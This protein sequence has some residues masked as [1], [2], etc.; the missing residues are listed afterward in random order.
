MQGQTITRNA[1]LCI[2]LVVIAG[3]VARVLA[4]APFDISHADELMQY[5]EQGHRLARTRSALRKMAS[6]SMEPSLAARMTSLGERKESLTD[7]ERHELL[8]LVDLYE[9]RSVEKLEA[10][11]ALA[12]IDRLDRQ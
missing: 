4:F 6:Y 5:L 2:A 8:E 12:D 7:E 9:R 1:W 3:L 11:L 10:L